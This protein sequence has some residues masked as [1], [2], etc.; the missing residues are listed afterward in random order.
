MHLQDVSGERRQAQI[1]QTFR[2]LG[3][4]LISAVTTNEVATHMLNAA[5][6]L[7]QWGCAFIDLYS[8]ETD[9]FESLLTI[10][11]VDGK[12]V[13]F[14]PQYEQLVPGSKTQRALEEGAFL[15]LREPDVSVPATSI[16]SFGNDRPS[17]S[18]MYVPMRRGSHNVGVMSI[19][20]YRYDAYT[21]A[22][23]SLLQELA[24]YCSTS[25]ER[26]NAESKAAQAEA[27]LLEN[28]KR[29]D[30]VMR[31]S[32]DSVYDYNIL[33][34]DIW[35]NQNARQSFS[36][37]ETDD[38]NR[39][40]WLAQ[41][42]PD[43][44]E[45]I[46]LELTNAMEQTAQSWSGEY[47]FRKAQGS[48]G[49][50]LDRGYISY[51]NGRA[52]RM[53]GTL[54][55]I[56]ARKQA[57]E[58]L[59]HGAYHDALTGLPNRAMLIEEVN[60]SLARTQRRQDFNIGLLFLDLDRFKMVNDSLGHAAG[61]E[62]LVLVAHAIKECVRPSDLV[63]RLG[64]DEFTVLLDDLADEQDA[65]AVAERILRR[66]Q[67][68]FNIQKNDVFTGTSI[69]IALS[70]SRYTTADEMLRDADT[71]MYR[72]KV[73]GKGRFE[74]FDLGMHAK[75]VYGLQTENDLRRAIQ[76]E[77]FVLHYQPLLNLPTRQIIG[78]EALIRWN[79][80]ER[81]LLPPSEFIDTAEETGLI[82]AIGEWV[83]RT[84]CTEA[85]QWETPA[86]G[87]PLEISVNVSARQFAEASFVDAVETILQETGLAP[88]RLNLEITESL[89][90]E[91]STQRTTD[92]HRL[93]AIG[94]NFH[95]DDF[96]TGYSSLS[97]LHKY[98]IDVLKIDRSFI[99][100]FDKE[101]D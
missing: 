64:G 33:T 91:A 71:A 66:L 9:K 59:R 62:L 79:H 4:N 44:R 68:P 7:F 72:A 20:S 83:L 70:S 51:E 90:V 36:T 93:K 76:A 12:R 73:A 38:W 89:L 87:K 48:Y 57:E 5:D 3:N 1:Q 43:D 49:N 58:Q 35:W 98:P 19:Q 50:F 56:T 81:G 25:F 32:N 29:F 45:Q 92:F 23:L 2:V 69:G 18:L 75:V 37:G 61:D 63:G 41:I 78:F 77:Q 28:Q 14:K 6:E 82:S 95:L 13:V 21:D 65:I 24:D 101:I 30:L 11:E 34:G 40:W 80:P 15:I 86:N 26:A 100:R 99:A 74:I 42:H 27:V 10:D 52:V 46:N 96:G 97:Y 85:L 54:M 94:I 60:R 8:Q 53:I 88:N 31:A 55:D 16:V 47:R 84:A 67:M 22:D 39:V 17:A